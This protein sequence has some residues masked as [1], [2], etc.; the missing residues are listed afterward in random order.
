MSSRRGA[1][2]LLFECHL[3]ETFQAKPMEILN[4]KTKASY[5]RHLQSTCF[6]NQSVNSFTKYDSTG[7][8]TKCL[9][10][11][12]C[13]KTCESGPIDTPFENLIDLTYGLC[14]LCSRVLNPYQ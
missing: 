14:S 8:H 11:L 1:R 2:L 13:L 10:L 9:Y 3:P 12:L 7:L 4:I 5:W 6:W